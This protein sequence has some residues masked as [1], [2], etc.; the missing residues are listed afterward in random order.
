V[1][2][3]AITGPD[4]DLGGY[5]KVVRDL[6]DRRDGEQALRAVQ[7]MLDSITDYEVIRLDRHPA[8]TPPSTSGAM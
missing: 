8:R 2:L 3:T 1:S 4:G 7:K 5:V 6:T